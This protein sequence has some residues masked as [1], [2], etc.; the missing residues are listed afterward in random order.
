M[1][2]QKTPCKLVILHI[3]VLQFVPCRNKVPVPRRAA[4]SFYCLRDSL[5]PPRQTE[6]LP[7]PSEQPGLL[8]FW[9]WHVQ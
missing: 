5:K 9:H 1:D 4:A 8:E 2:I 6:P 3:S 7:C